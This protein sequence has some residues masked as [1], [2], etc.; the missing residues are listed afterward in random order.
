MSS[1]KLLDTEESVIRR[2]SRTVVSWFKSLAVQVASGGSVVEKGTKVC[3][4]VGY[5]IE[6]SRSLKLKDGVNGVGRRG[7]LLLFPAKHNVD[8]TLGL[9][10]SVIPCSIDF[11]SLQSPISMNRTPDGNME[12]KLNTGA[13]LDARMQHEK[14]EEPLSPRSSSSTAVPRGEDGE[15]GKE[16]YVCHYCDAEFRIRGY[17]TRH[18]KKHAVEKAYHC[19]FF[20]GCS[21]PETRCHTTGGFSRR[22]TYKTHLR[23]RH[24][25]YPEGV[26]TQDRNR[27]PGHCAHCGKWFENTSKWIEKHI[28]SG[29]CTGLPEGTVLPAK[30]ARKA[31]KLK[32]IKTSTGRSRFITTQQSVVEP[33]VLLNKEAIEAMQIVVNETNSSG[34]PALTKLSDNRIML[35]STNFKGEP[36]T[37][38]AVKRQRR[39]KFEV[40]P[41]MIAQAP[42]SAA[43][44]ISMNRVS[45][46]STAPNHVLNAQMQHQNIHSIPNQNVMANYSF[47]TPDEAPLDEICLSLNPSPADDAGLEPVRSASSLSSHE[48]NQSTGNDMNKLLYPLITSNP[49]N[50]NDP[51]SVPL[52]VEQMAFTIPMVEPSTTAPTYRFEEEPQINVILNNQM[53]PVKLGERQLRET[54]QYLKFYNYNFDSSL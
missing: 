9:K 29:Y 11:S 32:M 17:L 31:G 25:I 50:L 7:E 43:S 24:F 12:W 44:F 10:S 26:K 5:G 4:D 2:V 15:G 52:D 39:R 14:L 53:D 1:G 51:Y 35:N 27:S 47:T 45:T 33:K 19:P 20:N 22:D 42:S 13:Q 46:T 6:K 54:Q 41:Y 8:Q 30:S 37:K 3:S 16:K 36:K 23:S 40:N 34:Q 48:C 49:L 21:P 28:E 18:I 38:K